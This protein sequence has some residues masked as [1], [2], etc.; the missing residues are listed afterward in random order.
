MHKK[1]K[2]FLKIHDFYDT[3]IKSYINNLQSLKITILKKLIS[4]HK[5]KKVSTYFLE[6]NISIKNKEVRHSTEIKKLG[7][8]IFS[9]YSSDSLFT[10]I[11]LLTCNMIIL[12]LEL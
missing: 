3:K 5:E 11:Q 1:K 10:S 2:K 7:R 4:I 6:L 8:N 12:C 9:Y